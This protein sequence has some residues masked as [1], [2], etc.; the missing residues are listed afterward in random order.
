MK[1]S[2]QSIQENSTPIDSPIPK[3]DDFK[4]SFAFS[5]PKIYLENSRSQGIPKIP[6]D[7]KSTLTET[8]G[9][10]M[11]D[12][13]QSLI[14]NRVK[15]PRKFTYGIEESDENSFTSHKCQG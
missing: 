7:R 11:Q 1:T 12:K 3:E 8:L 6:L 10:S 15:S 9:E 5:S 13:I 2:D 4:Q 14:P